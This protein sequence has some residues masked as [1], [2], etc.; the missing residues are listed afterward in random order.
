MLFTFYALG[1]VAQF[2]V[3]DGWIETRELPN[4]EV[5]GALAQVFADTYDTDVSVYAGGLRV[6][7]VHPL[8]PGFM[9]CLQYAVQEGVY[10]G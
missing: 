9:Q 8:L 5:A 4:A 10:A 3:R 7:T 1:D 2:S 6:G